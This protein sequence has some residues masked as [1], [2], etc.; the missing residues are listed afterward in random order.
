M[1]FPVR[2]W[3]PFIFP[4]ALFLVLLLLLAVAPQAAAWGDHE[5]FV[6]MPYIL[7]GLVFLLGA[8]FNQSR[9]SFLC[10]LLV[11]ITF[12]LQ[13][14]FFIRP[15]PAKGA[16]VVFLSSVYFPPLAVLFYHLGE[17]GTFNRH[18]LIRFLLVLSAVIVIGL[19]PIIP[20]VAERMSSSPSVLFQPLSDAIQV[21]LIGVLL[22][23]GGIPLLLIRNKHESPNLGRLFGFAFLFVLTALNLRSGGWPEGGGK[24][25]LLLFM[26]GASAIL[27]WAVLE[28]SWR[29]AHIDELTEL[30]GRRALKHRLASLGSSYAIAVIDIDFFKKINDRYGHDTGDQVLRFVAAHLRRNEKN[31]AYRYGG[32]EFVIIAEDFELAAMVSE[33]EELRK[34][35]DK[36]RF[37]VRSKDRPKEK[38]EVPRP[39]TTGLEER[40]VKVT[41]SIGVAASRDKYDS[42][43]AVLIAADKALYRAKKDGRNCVKASR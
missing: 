34:A 7:F 30:P 35:I 19:L 21:P 13:V 37:V 32:E 20:A 27:A 41:V 26:S 3:A 16:A 17:R 11:A 6:S 28:S 39:S 38:P 40:M 5:A 10:L 9:V 42:P 29:S 12:F 43:D 24:T 4:A 15:N 23:A 18:G 2:T 31:R 25:V 33:M 36:S 22:F 1:I 8:F 14:A